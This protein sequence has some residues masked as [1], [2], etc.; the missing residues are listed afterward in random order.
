[1]ENLANFTSLR[2]GGP[3]RKIVHAKSESE[4]IDFVR[5][6]DEASEPLLILGGGSNVLIGDEGFAGT[7]VIVETKGNALDVEA[8]SGGMIEVAAGEDW[9]EFVKL[10]IEKGFAGLETLSGIPG[11]VGGAPIQNIGAYGHEVS[12]TIARV[13]TFDRMER[14]IHSFSA[15]ECKFSYRDSIFKHSSN[16]YVV[17]SVTFQLR[18]GEFSDPIKYPELATQL[19]ISVGEKANTKTVR[20][21]VLEIRNRK[22]MLLS[23]DQQSIRSAGSFFVNPIISIAKA[24]ELPADA[25]RWNQPDG[26]VKTSAAWLLEH[27]GIKKGEKLSGA[28]VSDL[29]VL[30]FTNSGGATAKDM[31]ELAKFAKLK[32]KER[33]GIELE[34]EVQLIGCDLD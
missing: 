15:S 7:V 26:R 11:T 30:A 33:F 5:S 32:V 16:R 2:I 1:M 31:V 27:A 3:A 8:C 28:K 21:A 25:P 17:L 10:S 29:H 12:E 18:I 4:L 20:N 9:D 24:N 13:K 34:P 19:G 14:K 23:K 6:A 22:G